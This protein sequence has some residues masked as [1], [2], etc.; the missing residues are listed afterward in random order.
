MKICRRCVVTGK[1]QGVFF[2]QGTFDQA[3]ALGITG[4]V[5]NLPTG[6]VECLI[7]G[8]LPNVEALCKWLKQGPPAAKVTEVAITP[9]PWQEYTTFM[10][11]R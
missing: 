6:E 10:I 7:C 1:V 3:Q 8:D 11:L 2:R 5:K 9:L 4:W